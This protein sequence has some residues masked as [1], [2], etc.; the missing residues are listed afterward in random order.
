M[1]QLEKEN[2]DL[3]MVIDDQ[4]MEINYLKK[5]IDHYKLELTKP[6]KPIYIES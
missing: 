4:L 3:R 2:I 1:I 6:T 5:E